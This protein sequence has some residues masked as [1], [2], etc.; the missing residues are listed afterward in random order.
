[1]ARRR[2]QIVGRRSGV[3]AGRS[4]ASRTQL[5]ANRRAQAAFLRGM[6]ALHQFEYEDAN[7]AFR[8]ARELDP[9]FVMAYW[10]EAMTYH[11]TLWRNENVEAAR[12]TLARLAPRP[13]RAARRPRNAKEQAW[14]G[15]VE[16][17]F[18]DGDAETRRRSYA[19]A[20]AQLHAREPDDPDVASLYAL[21]LLGT[22]S[23][24]LIGYVDS[25]EGHS[26]A[27]AGSAIQAQVAEILEGVLRS[28]PEHPGA[29]HYLLHNQDDPAHAH[30]A[31][32]AART[33]ARLAPESSHTRHMP[34]HIFFQLGLWQDAA[35]SD[36]AAFAASDAWVARKR[37]DA[38]MRNYHALVVAAVRAAPAREVPRRVGHHRRAR[39]GRRRAQR[40]AAGS[41]E[42]SCRRCARA[43]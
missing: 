22:M 12:L 7:E 42:R 9:G 30:R 4:P 40:A 24:S 39:A 8:Q 2:L 15:A 16:R 26:Q 3:S 10:G 21:A 25:H 38:A 20:M 23:R 14:L 29:L 18:G 11:Q 35:R 37:L 6:A 32:A 36:R 13:P 41:S 1:M 31:L 43:T 17:L 34:A 5:G 28:H 33:L 19:D 27:L